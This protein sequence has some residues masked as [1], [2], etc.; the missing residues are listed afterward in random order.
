MTS[1]VTF[2]DF[3]SSFLSDLFCSHSEVKLV[4]YINSVAANEIQGQGSRV[5]NASGY[6]SGGQWFESRLG[7]MFFF[8]PACAYRSRAILPTLV[9]LCL[10]FHLI[11]LKLYR[12]LR[13]SS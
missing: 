6:K 7:K 3:H 9:G 2:S 13:M 12:S 4:A 5:V 11:F 10:I 8:S 1:Q